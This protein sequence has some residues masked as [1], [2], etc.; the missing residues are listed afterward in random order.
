M[1]D[2]CCLIL[3]ADNDTG[4]TAHGY[5]YCGPK[6]P[7]VL[8]PSLKE[9]WDEINRRLGRKGSYLSGEDVQLYNFQYKMNQTKVVKGGSPFDAQADGYIIENL[10]ML[11]AMWNNKAVCAEVLSHLCIFCAL[12]HCLLLHTNWNYHICLL[13]LSRRLS[14]T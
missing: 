13:L 14:F 8:P 5:W 1:N 9:P 2:E 4:M 3:S 11:Q 10:N 7:K 6:E 12:H